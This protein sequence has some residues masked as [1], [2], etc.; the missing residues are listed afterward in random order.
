MI[1]RITQDAR[2][3]EVWVN[4]RAVCAMLADDPQW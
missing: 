2:D 4:K 1:L 3:V